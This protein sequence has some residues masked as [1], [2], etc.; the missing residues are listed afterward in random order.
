MTSVENLINSNGLSSQPTT[1]LDP[2]ALITLK[3]LVG[4]GGLDTW[5]NQ[6]V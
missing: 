5:M 1:F 6:R 4:E 3:I 2:R